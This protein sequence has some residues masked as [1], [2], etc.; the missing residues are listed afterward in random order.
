[1]EGTRVGGNQQYCWKAFSRGLKLA[2]S[3]ILS[4]DCALNNQKPIADGKWP[5]AGD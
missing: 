2:H 3:E 1:M 5:I 4:I